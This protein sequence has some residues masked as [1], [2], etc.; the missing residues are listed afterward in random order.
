MQILKPIADTEWGAQRVRGELPHPGR[1]PIRIS[2]VWATPTSQINKNT[3]RGSGNAG[4]SCSDQRHLF[5]CRHPIF[6]LS[7]CTAGPQW[8]GASHH[9][10]CRV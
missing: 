6:A 2:L 3:R 10:L 1:R 5:N 8:S 4:S 7:C 9:L